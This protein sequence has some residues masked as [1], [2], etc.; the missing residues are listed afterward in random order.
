MTRTERSTLVCCALLGVVV[1]A[2]GGSSTN[3]R[4]CGAGHQ[5]VDGCMNNNDCGRGGADVCDMATMSCV[6]CR[7]N[8][9][10]G[11]GSFCLPDHTCQ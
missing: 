3:Q 1:M 8:N 4:V 7:T 5:C 9:D 10:C 11:G 6:E 2:C